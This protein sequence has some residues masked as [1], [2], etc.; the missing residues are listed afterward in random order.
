MEKQY[1][2]EMRQYNVD[3]DWG[4]AFSFASTSKEVF[5]HIKLGEVRSDHEVAWSKDLAWNIFRLNEINGKALSFSD[6]I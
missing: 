6:I 2:I 4:A 3:E 5:I 1:T